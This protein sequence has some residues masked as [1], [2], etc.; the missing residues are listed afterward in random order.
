MPGKLA[1]R[2][3]KTR[4]FYG[5]PTFTVLTRLYSL[6]SPQAAEKAGL[7]AKQAHSLLGMISTA[8]VKKKLMEVT[9]VACKYGVSDCV[10]PS[11]ILKVQPESLWALGS[12][13]HESS[14]ALPDNPF[15]PSSA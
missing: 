14:S 3:G 6:M 4:I 11:P 9:E 5:A 13:P 8:E 1:G 2:K 12:C 15:L 7:S 10:F